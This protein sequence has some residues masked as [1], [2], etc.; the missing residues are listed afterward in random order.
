MAKAKSKSNHWE[1]EAKADA[2]KIERAEKERD[3]VKQEAKVARLK[4]VAAGDG[5]VR[6]EDNLTRVLNA[7]AAAEED[8][9]RLEAEVV[10][11]AVE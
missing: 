4:A 2:K 3:E 1:R 7:L 8:D 5:K 9:R 11:L 10:R 6:V